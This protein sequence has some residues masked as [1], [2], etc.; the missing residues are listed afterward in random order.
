MQFTKYKIVLA[1]NSPRRQELLKLMGIDFR[2]RIKPVDENYPDGLTPDEVARYLC[3]KKA[4]AFEPDELSV[5]EL[6]ITADTIVCLGGEIMNKPEDRSHAIEMLR[7]LS[8]KKHQVITGVALRSLEKMTSFTVS[9]DVVFK[10][11]SDDDISFYVDNYKP[12][13]KAGAYGIQEWIGFVGIE[14]IDGSYFNVV[15]LPTARL[16]KELEEF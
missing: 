13:D 4:M 14:R 15:G 6:L 1:S 3:E 9:T 5:G 8:G 2:I 7:K 16:Y 12:F 11:L 10:K